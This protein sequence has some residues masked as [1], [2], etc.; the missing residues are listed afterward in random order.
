MYRYRAIIK[1]V[2]DGDTL[3]VDIDLGFNITKIGEMIRLYGIN[4]EESRGKAKTDKGLL[5]KSRVQALLSTGQEIQLNTIKDKQE[6]YG[7]FL[8][9]V[10]L[11]DGRELNQLLLEEKLATE[12]KY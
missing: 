3:E 7:R 6:K 5:A 12:I 2:V 9:I 10:Y 4:T 1:K 11:P 8:A